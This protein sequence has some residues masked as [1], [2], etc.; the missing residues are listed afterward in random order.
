MIT[1]TFRPGDR[2]K[3]VTEAHG[4][5]CDVLSATTVLVMFDNGAVTYIPFKDLTKVVA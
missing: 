4:T 1:S 5:V 3:F 2:V